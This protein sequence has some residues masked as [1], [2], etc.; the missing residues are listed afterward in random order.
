MIPMFRSPPLGIVLTLCVLGSAGAGLGAPK[1]SKSTAEEE[2]PAESEPKRPP[3]MAANAT[4]DPW[5]LKE[6]DAQPPRVQKL[7]SRASILP[8]L[9]LTY[10]YGSADPDRG[11]MDCSGTI[12]YLLRSQGFRE[13]PRA[14]PGQ[15]LWT[16]DAGGFHAVTSR[17]MESPEFAELLPGDLLF[18]SGTYA[19]E[20]EVPVTHV[21]LYLGTEKKTKKRVMF[22]ASN[23]RSYRG[24][25]RWGVSVFDFKMPRAGSKAVF[26]GYGRIPGLRKESGGDR[27]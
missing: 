5:D 15:Y 10:T 22:G 9:G 27:E 13:V 3:G 6:Y 21:M 4:I 19:I 8:A 24:K 23:G 18:W 17:K 26:L 25:A 16:R 1:K 11:G 14:S 2:S 7:I 12:Y 20:R